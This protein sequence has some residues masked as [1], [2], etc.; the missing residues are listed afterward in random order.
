MA[1]ADEVVTALEQA[2]QKLADAKSKGLQG[3]SMLGKVQTSV[4]HTLGRSGAAS[5][6]LSQL[7]AKEK[8]IVE[9]VMRLDELSARLDRAIAEARSAPVTGVRGRPTEPPR[10][11]P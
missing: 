5:P 11:E 7:R 2:K 6:L 4:S 3:A 1:T 8:A 9:Q 10:R